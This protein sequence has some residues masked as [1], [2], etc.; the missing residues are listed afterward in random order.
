MKY[1]STRGQV[2]G[3]E[4]SRTLLEGLAPDG[5]LY[6]PEEWP[7]M[8]PERIRGFARK[9]YPEIVTEVL[10]DFAGEE[11]AR[12]DLAALAERAAG[13][14]RGRVVAPLV[15]LGPD[16]WLLEL[17]H[18]P[19]YAFKDLAMQLLSPLAD[20]ALTRTD[21]RALLITATSGDTGGAAVRAFAGAER[22]GLAVFHPLGRVSPV[23]RR[24]MTTTTADNVLNIAVEGDFD[25]CQRIV[26]ALL[27]DASLRADRRLSS[28]NSINWAR[29]AGQIPYYLSAA[30]A[31]GAP[32][33]KIRFV[34]PTGNFGDAFAG[35]AAKRMG[36]GQFDFIA[37]VNQNDA[38]ARVLETGTY[39]RRA[40]VESASVSMDVQAPSNFERMVFEAAGRDPEPTKAFFEA[41]AA[42]GEARL[43]ENLH[44]ALQREVSA[45]AIDEN[46]T[47]ETMRAALTEYHQLICPHTAVGLAAAKRAEPFDGPTVVL[48]TAH[49]AKFPAA[50]L[51]ATGQEPPALIE[52]GGAA[53]RY[54]IIAP[55]VDRA[56]TLL[57]ERFGMAPA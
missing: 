35:W 57:R 25:D 19:T 1:V 49:P 54:E 50:V 27:G 7:R 29:L 10:E 5:G 22:V 14:F 30:A 39:T 31:L 55:D 17:F 21:E 24:Q 20:R 18:G 33:R 28:V 32:E 37:A 8:T 9:T 38:L 56:R 4:F 43:P 41:F 15:Q 47:A 16:L 23:Q 40:A 34:V 52:D 3:V 13:V 53:E 42:T 12:A 51:A 26:K 46:E 48:A 2:A 11:F 45:I 6:A 36:A 44:T